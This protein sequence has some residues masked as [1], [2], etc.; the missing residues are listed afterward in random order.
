MFLRQFFR[1][2]RKSA[3]ISSISITILFLFFLLGTLS[4]AA[5]REK[6]R[7]SPEKTVEKEVKKEQPETDS[8]DGSVDVPSAMAAAFST[9]FS[10]MDISFDTVISGGPPKDGIPAID[11]PRFITTDEASSWISPTE[12]VIVVRKGSTSKIYPLQILMFHEIVNDTIEELPIAITYCPLCNT[13]IVYIREVGNKTLDFGTTGRLRY[14]NLLMYD[15]QTESWWQQAN[16]TAVIGELLGETLELYPAL[17]LPWKD[18]REEAPE[19]KVLSRDTGYQR[20]YGENP[21]AGY[22]SGSPFLLRGADISEEYDPLERLLVLK[23]NNE[24]KLYPYSDL[25]EERVINDTLGNTDIVVFWF[26]GTA[27]ALDSPN[28]AEGK[29]VGT[30]NG[31]IAEADGK[32]LSF[33]T[34]QGEIKD[35]QSGSTWNA[36]GRAISGP[37]EGSELRP[38]PAE[39]HFWFSAYLFTKASGPIK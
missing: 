23:L 20:P 24:T 38:V 19:G 30:A 2:V 10:K 7:E 34:Q 4:C 32:P 6:V 3:G 37:L 28:I 26:P 35:R 9:D 14:S 33:T 16:G 12:P 39:Q 36:A 17:T 22:D 8:S 15:R 11:N 1:R 29:D 5:D 13:S 21:Y 25:R 18:A 27:S 31:F